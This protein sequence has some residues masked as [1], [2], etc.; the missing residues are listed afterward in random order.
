MGD[1]GNIVIRSSQNNRDD[2]WFYTHWSG[3]EI[4]QTVAQAL[5]KKWRW[6]DSTYLARIIF[7]ELTSGS[8]GEETGFGISTCLQDNEH[9]IIVVD[10]EK[11]WVFL[12]HEKQLVDGRIPNDFK[13]LKPKSYEDFVASVA[14]P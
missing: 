7:D 12:I 2:V 14:V 3:S 8:H 13:P 6:G 10:D 5:A 1:R 9:P 4:G 11:Q